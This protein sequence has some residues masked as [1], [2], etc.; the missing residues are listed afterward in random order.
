[1]QRRE[2][3]LLYKTPGGARPEGKPRVYFTC[4]PADF[5]TYFEKVCADLFAAHDCAV[6]Y[7]E[8]MEGALPE[9]T[10]E[11]D[12]D[13]MN[14]FVIPVTTRLLVDKNRAMDEDFAFAKEKHIPVL[15]LMMQPGLD[16]IYSREDRFGALQYLDPYGKNATAISYEEKLEKYLE[17]VLVSDET[18]QRIRAAFDAYIF[19]SYRKKDRAFA[20]TLMR[21]IHSHPL[22]RDIAVW[23]DE[24]LTPGESFSANIER[25]LR[26]SK[27]FALLVTPNLLEDP[28]FVMD[29]EYPAA[30]DAGMEIL[31]AEMTPTDR[32]A[33]AAKYAGLPQPVNA[34]DEA[35][36]LKALSEAVSAFAK[37]ENDSDP[38]H[39]YLIGLAYLDGIDVET[40]RERALA[41]ITEAGEADLPEAMKKLYVMYREG[42][43]VPLSYEKS[44]YW[45][46]KNAAC[47]K[48]NYGEEDER[49]LTA[50]YCLACTYGECGDHK[51]ALELQEKYY[52]L[53]CK[54]LGEE[55]T[56]TL[57]SLNN[58][59]CI[60]DY[61][62][63][64]KKALELLE[65]CYVLRCRVLGEEHP[66]TLTT[67]GNLS[68][69]YGELG[70][71]KKAL[72]QQ[73]KCY[74]LCCNV[75]GE[76]HPRTLTIL[77]Y[78][79]LTY[80]KLGEN[81]KEA[82]VEEKCYALKC[83]ILG[84]EHPD[85]L[86]SLS[87]LATTY[88]NL[89]EYQKA[90]ELHEKCYALHCK[91]LG[92]EHPNTLKS[93]SVLAS[94]YGELGEHRKA[95]E[96]QKKCYA[97]F[98]K[99]LGEEH[100]DTLTALSNLAS[101]Y[102]NLGE[103][104]KALELHEKYYALHCKILG[105]EHPSTLTSLNNLAYF[106]SELSDY[107]R[108]RE[109][110]EKC[111]ALRCKVLGEEHPDTITSLSNLASTFFDLGDY[112]KAVKLGEKCYAI[113]CH[114]LGVNHPD[115]IATQINLANFFA[116]CG[117]MMVTIR[118]TKAYVYIK[119]L[120]LKHPRTLLAVFN[121]AISCY[122]AGYRTTAL[123]LC[124]TLMIHADSLSPKT[125]AKT[126]AL[127]DAL[128]APEKAKKL[129]GE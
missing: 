6:Y 9:A 76:E 87:N 1:M 72:K 54:V 3:K 61:L 67:L 25:A 39:N 104:Q 47:C 123:V 43:G 59:A 77:S 94:T 88:G 92:E 117:S 41:L 100:S 40:D 106:Y 86:L 55:H 13:R 71:H 111:Y 65:K 36:F 57:A 62:D 16:P 74:A 42:R 80:G 14:L 24:F 38:A 63:D 37:A 21:L 64:H 60:Y 11:T 118:F 115:T 124:E 113:E 107:A 48:K 122:R 75:L 26:D 10:R 97:L 34:N 120:G 84:E 101:S 127:F 7:T 73:E 109:L 95:L 15:P 114:I 96:L 105:E 112:K 70:N 56:L 12:L 28:N 19:L 89:G 20:N 98:C 52:A 58:L 78:L 2:T 33:L 110:F 108:A 46:R 17:A 27:L 83:R 29:V 90:R 8:D 53:S 99:V 4:H 85:T 22:C 35:A 44:L 18:V 68:A 126:A 23:Y 51:K 50:L 125:K 5:E 45:A 93:L 79:A 128:G 81:R 103:Y 119:N 49:T 91:V 121:A 82:E 30:R 129:R 116:K 69:I 66:D 32:A 102:G 31:P